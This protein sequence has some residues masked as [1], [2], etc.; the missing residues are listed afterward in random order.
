MNRRGLRLAGLAGVGFIALLAASV[1]IEGARPDTFA[2]DEAI[3][4]FFAD[5]AN[6]NR[7]AGAALL[8]IPAAALFL[9]FLA[10]LHDILRSDELAS[11]L[12][13][14]A[15]AGGLWFV[16][17]IVLAKLVDNITGA[18]LAFSDA[19]RIDPQEARLTSALA[20]WIQGASMAGAAVLV[21]AGSLLARRAGLIGRRSEYVGYALAVSAPAA[22]ALNG[23]PI[24]LF[25]L[26]VLI[27]GIVLAS[28][29]PGGRRVPNVHEGGVNDGNE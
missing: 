8:L 21:A 2:S 12:S 1:L 3:Q 5:T 16:A 28:G 26:W 15:V 10:G 22:V 13:A 18:S 17:F 24:L 6:Q 20:Y 25:L 11:G 19:Y 23:V 29:R 9:F 7:A 27:A 14:A 4:R